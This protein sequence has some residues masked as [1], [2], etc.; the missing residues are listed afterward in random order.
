MTQ[1]V[2]HLVDTLI[3]GGEVD[4]S[5]PVEKREV[6]IANEI[7]LSAE[8]LKDELMSAADPELVEEIE[9]QFDNIARLCSEL[10]TIHGQ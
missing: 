2:K 7:Q 8:A 1:S 10:K 3:E 6:Q 5:D 9:G 4:M